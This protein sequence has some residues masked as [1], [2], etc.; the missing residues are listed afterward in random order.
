MSRRQSDTNTT[1][2]SRSDL[3]V[4]HVAFVAHLRYLRPRKSVHV[5]RVVVNVNPV[6]TNTNTDVN[7]IGIL[8]NGALNILF[9]KYLATNCTM[10]N[11]ITERLL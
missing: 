7:Q 1:H 6:G 2:R 11:K 4:E 9:K 5:Q 10:A 3:H 8:S